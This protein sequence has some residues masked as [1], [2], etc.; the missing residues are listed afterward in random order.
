MQGKVLLLEINFNAEP[1]IYEVSY[2]EEYD[3]E[4]QPK[5]EETTEQTEE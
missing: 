4:N 3:K 5:T 2:L 1:S